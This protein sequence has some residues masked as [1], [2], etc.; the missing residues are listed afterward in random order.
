[1]K[2]AALIHGFIDAGWFL[3]TDGI[4]RKFS[5]A[6][7]AFS[8]FARE[9]FTLAEIVTTIAV[10]AIIGAIA[11]QGYQGINSASRETVARDNLALLNR[12]LLHFNQGVKDITLSP[13]YAS[14]SDE[15]TILRTLQW[16]DEDL[17]GS[18]YLS[19]TFTGGVSSSTEDYRICWNGRFFELLMPGT[20][21]IGIKAGLATPEAEVEFNYPEGYKPLDTISNE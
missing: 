17:P 5:K 4:G 10:V 15:L 1:M 7:K 19:A 20:Q 9:G 16:R 14:A 13:N 6:G 11:I 8:G 2:H 3:K 18:P 12:S 21:G